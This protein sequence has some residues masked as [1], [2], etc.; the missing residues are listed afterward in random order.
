MDDSM[1]ALPADAMK[2][3][4]DLSTRNGALHAPVPA[5]EPP[6][7]RVLGRV[8]LLLLSIGFIALIA[9]VA[10]SVTLT[11]RDQQAFD[12][13]NTTQQLLD[14]IDTAMQS[15][16]DAETGQRGFLLTEREPYLEP[17]IYASAH[18]TGQLNALVAETATLP[19]A[20]TARDFHDKGMAK[21]AE[22][23]DTISLYKNN[24]RSAAMDEVLT[25]KGRIY[26]EQARLDAAHMRRV[27]E[28]QLTS[29]LM[30][31]RRL[32][33]F[34]LAAQVGTAGL[35]LAIALLTGF[36]LARNVA[37]LRRA[38][39][40]LSATNANLED[41]VALR[42]RALSLAND[43]I[44]KFAYIVSH[45]LRAPLVNI[46]GF[47]S[48]LETAART[49][50]R[51]VDARR[52]A[53]GSDVPRDVIDAIGEDMPEAF[54]F[55]KT[56]TTKMDRLI[57]AI[58]KLSREG[59][60]ILTPEALAMAPLLEN[61]R[62]TLQHKVS[63]KNAHIIIEPVPNLISDRLAIEQIFGNLLDN[64]VKY[65]A[66]GRPGVITVRGVTKPPLAIFEVED[67]GRGIA[68]GD[69]ERVFELFRRSGE[70][71]IPGEGIGLAYVRQLIY[72]LGGTIELESEIGKGTI[73]RLS[74]PMVGTKS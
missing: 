52:K 15:L 7:A 68:S 51:Y 55:I 73:F 42:T 74:L 31:A 2:E 18:L 57:G 30:T 60:R 69:R 67:N 33:G 38:Q 43:E 66:P 1:V 16:E 3:D 19:I 64:A 39:A 4:L 34:L 59:R 58:L 36:G 47:T 32:G 12:L 45:D 28:T 56:S 27:E 49:V 20:D 71:N 29:R 70:Q 5:A 37:A 41:I 24:G 61:I 44:Q 10:A 53:E 46:M 50:G 65:L 9:I 63:E 54:T 13:A 8:H 11:E 48:E 14:D 25:D 21:L 40:A 23:A 72:R 35:V 6:V 26:M 62:A 22:L 17:Y